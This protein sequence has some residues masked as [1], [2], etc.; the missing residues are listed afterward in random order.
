VLAAWLPGE[1]WRAVTEAIKLIE[2]FAEHTPEPSGPLADEA[3]PIVEQGHDAMVKA[4][5][6]LS[7][8]ESVAEHIFEPDDVDE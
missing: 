6:A 5:I 3:R 2:L 7:T 4:V 1:E 8:L